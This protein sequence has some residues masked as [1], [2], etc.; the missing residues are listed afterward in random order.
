M[1]FWRQFV[2]LI[3]L[4]HQHV[5]IGFKQTTRAWIRWSCSNTVTSV[6]ATNEMIWYFSCKFDQH[7]FITVF[8]CSK[9]K[10]AGDIK[11]LGSC[12]SLM[13]Y[14]FQNLL[15]TVTQFQKY[16]WKQLQFWS[17]EITWS[18]MVHSVCL[19]PVS[20]ATWHLNTL[21]YFTVPVYSR[22][23]QLHNK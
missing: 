12:E 20:L 5:D 6:C 22:L 19:T 3:M 21:W 18:K 9:T 13:R 10:I 7:Y 8:W 23:T 2:P 15:T 11:I 17:H 14:N 1:S 16:T 4:S